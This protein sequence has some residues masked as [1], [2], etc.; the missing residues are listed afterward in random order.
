MT[1]SDHSATPAPKGRTDTTRPPRTRRGSHRQPY[2]NAPVRASSPRRDAPRA[3]LSRHS[4]TAPTVP[5]PA[6]VWAC[7][8]TAVDPDATW[9]APILNKIVTSFSKSGD[10]VVLM[11]WPT[12]T[13]QP[14][15]ALRKTG[16]LTDRVPTAA[17]DD[18]LATAL[19]AI[20]NLD[21]TA[22]LIHLQRDPT[23]SGPAS[24]PFWADLLQ[25]PEAPHP[26]RTHRH[27]DY[28]PDTAASQLDA[29]TATTDLIITSLRPEHSGDRASDHVAL[30]A[31][32]LLRVG[33]ILAVLT[34][35][36]WS[37][38]ELRDPTGTVVASAQN[39]DLLYLQ[40]IIA[41]HTPI[42]RGHFHLPPAL[43]RAPVQ[44]HTPRRPAPHHRISS[45][46][47]VFAQPHDHQPPPLASTAA[48]KT[49]T[50]R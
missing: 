30:L 20:D 35:S 4:R 27:T 5:T 50:H 43:T 32:R 9:P 2:P 22:A 41:L 48:I 10:R 49:A 29:T 31:A 44:H 33:G 40:H 7:G 17:P 47:L 13:P 21:R 16:G 3:S 36:D 18:Q 15:V 11:P 25:T 42:H 8:P 26:F 39:A 34:H 6:T 14:P 24:R 38:G 28:A 12:A 46:V 37:S 23:A 19:A 1:R 45:D